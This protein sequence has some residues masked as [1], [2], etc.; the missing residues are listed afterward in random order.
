M[1]GH[2]LLAVEPADRGWEFRVRRCG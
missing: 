1:K 2:R